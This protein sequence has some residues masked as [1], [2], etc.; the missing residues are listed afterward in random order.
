MAFPT[1]HVKALQI[2]V[3][4]HLER[5]L[6]EKLSTLEKYIG[7]ETD[8]QCEAEFAKVAP[9]HSGAVYRVEVNLWYKGTLYRAEATE[10]QFEKAIDEVRNELDKELR[11]AHKKRE[12]LFRRGRRMIKDMMRF[13]G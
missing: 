6:Q 8:V 9:H 2:E 1:V 10:D 11:R 7:D 5:L 13:G 4:P 12:N 3:A